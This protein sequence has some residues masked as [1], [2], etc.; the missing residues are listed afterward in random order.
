MAGYP[1]VAQKSALA[2]VTDAEDHF[3]ATI[4][5]PADAPFVAPKF[6]KAPPASAGPKRVGIERIG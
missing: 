6:R 2:V 1:G 3:T 5:A 4:K